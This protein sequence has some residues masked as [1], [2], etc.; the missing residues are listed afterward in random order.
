MTRTAD[1]TTYRAHSIT[2]ACARFDTGTRGD[3]S[4]WVF[5]SDL[6]LGE[7]WS[8]PSITDM[9]PRTCPGTWPAA[10]KAL[11]VVG[12]LTVTGALMGASND[13]R[14]R[15]AGAIAGADTR[16]SG[17]RVVAVSVPTPVKIQHVRLAPAPG[18]EQPATLLEFDMLNDSVDL[19]TDVVVQ[20][21]IV[22]KSTDRKTLPRV[23]AGPFTI[24]GETVIKPGY[25]INYQMLMR[26]LSSDCDCIANVGVLSAR[27]LTGADR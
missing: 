6:T 15:D 21:S 17:D 16:P 20:I 23:L 18:A 8:Y 11:F 25:T 26:N 4:H 13:V 27:P 10:A 12:I 9:T 2:S 7:R 14:P 5:W 22:E 1:L 24:K 19:I 3:L